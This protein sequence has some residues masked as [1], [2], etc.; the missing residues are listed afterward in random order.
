METHE[1]QRETSQASHTEAIVS[2]LKAAPYTHQHPLSSP[3]PKGLALR[4]VACPPLHPHCNI[5]GSLREGRISPIGEAPPG[6]CHYR[7]Q[8]ASREPSFKVRKN[9]FLQQQK[10]KSRSDSTVSRA[11]VLNEADLDSIL[12]IPYGSLSITRS[13]S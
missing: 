2:F 3:S 12:N 11:F 7:R 10:R 8:S 4:A 5:Q 9:P 13:D 1:V 6:N